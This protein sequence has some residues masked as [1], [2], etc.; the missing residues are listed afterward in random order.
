VVV[1]AQAAP[2]GGY[3]LLAV[4]QTTSITRA[5]VRFNSANGP[6]LNIQPLPYSV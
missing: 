3:D 6:T 5:T 2:D 4:I 1:N